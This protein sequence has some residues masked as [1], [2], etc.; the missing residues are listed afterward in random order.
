MEI[1][2]TP[3][4]LKYSMDEHLYKKVQL[5]SIVFKQRHA[6]LFEEMEWNIEMVA[7]LPNLFYFVWFIVEVCWVKSNF[8]LIEF[9]I[10]VT[11]FMFATLLVR[12]W[13]YHDGCF[14]SIILLP[15]NL[16]KKYFI[17]T[18]AVLFLSIFVCQKWHLF[19]I[20]IAIKTTLI[21]IYGL[22]YG[23]YQ[24]LAPVHNRIAESIIEFATGEAKK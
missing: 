17:D 4:G 9:I 5:Y 3:Q 19:L 21:W 20:Y 12:A 22:T 18:V 8:S 1:Y 7:L 16:I 15:Y 23:S 24:K 6:T 11:A 10:P 2:Q 13:N 14:W